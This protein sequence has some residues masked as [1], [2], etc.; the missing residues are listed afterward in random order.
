MQNLK[1]IFASNLIA[2]R[3]NA[4]LTQSDLAA[5][6]NYSDKSISKWERAEAI[7]D[8]MVIKSLSEI[9]GVTVDYMLSSH[10]EWKPEEKEP[11]FERSFNEKIVI[12][13]SILGIWTLAILL[14]AICWMAGY[15]LWVIFLAAIPASLIT[16]LVMNIVWHG[17]IKNEVIVGIL[18]LSIYILLY[19]I[20]RDYDPWK[21]LL[22]LVPSEL[23]VYLSF[24]IKKKRKR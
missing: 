17:K 4:G 20:L 8:V 16:L 7:P 23:I 15:I 19:Y 22:V 1:L 10:D 14:F 6:I 21:L 12:L 13:I 11:L 5:K 9:F 18:I 3:S 2:L 24:R